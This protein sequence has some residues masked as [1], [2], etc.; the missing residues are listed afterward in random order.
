MALAAIGAGAVI[1]SLQEIAVQC[2]RGAKGGA[3]YASARS[4]LVQNRGEREA[5]LEHK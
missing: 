5:W 2:G 1:H 4:W 3:R